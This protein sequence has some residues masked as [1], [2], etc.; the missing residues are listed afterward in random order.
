MQIHKVRARCP[1]CGAERMAPTFTES[2]EVLAI[3]CDRCADEATAQAYRDG[4]DVRSSPRA[5]ELEQPLLT[6]DM[7]EF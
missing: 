1:R 6:P 2:A 7:E 3:C 5:S 4:A